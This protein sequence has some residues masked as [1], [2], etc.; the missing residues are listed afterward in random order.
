M[1]P[2]LLE[3]KLE[4]ARSLQQLG[5]LA[6]SR[7]IVLEIL[8]IQADQFDALNLLGVLAAQSGDFDAALGHFEAALRIQPDSGA[9]H[10]NR[11]LV[12]Q[13]ERRYESALESFDIAISLD[14]RNI[15]AH[16]GRGNVATQLGLFES[17]LASYDRVLEI[18]PHFFQAQ[19]SRGPLLQKKNDWRSALAAYDTALTINP[20]SAEAHCGRASV[21]YELE[22]FAAAIEASDRSIALNATFAPIHLYR[23]N[24]LRQLG[25]LEEALAT[26]D[27]AISLDPRFAEAF[28]NRGALLKIMGRNDAALSSYDRAITL[29]PQYADAY[30]NRALIH[31]EFGRHDAAAK[32]LESVAGIEPAL[33]FLPGSFLEARM[34]LC[35]WSNL[36]SQLAHLTE[37][38]ER[39]DPASPPFAVLSLVDSPR[40]QLK[41]AETWVRTMCPPND[42]LGRIG[43][44]LPGRTVRIGYF[45]PDF[46]VHPVG[47]LMAEILECHDHSRFEIIGFYFG[48]DVHDYMRARLARTFTQFFDVR[49][50]SATEIAGLARSLNVD[51][52]VDLCGYTGGSRPMIF[53][54]RAAP[55][56]I[57]YLGYPGTMG[58][59]YMDYLI[60]DS[61]V[62]PADQRAHYSE[63]IIYL[64][65]SFLPSD[66]TRTIS[67]RIFKRSELGLPAVG[68]VYCCFNNSYKIGP[69]VFNTWMRILSRVANSVLWLS[70]TNPTAAANLRQAADRHGI[71]E[72]RII[73]AERMASP[74]EHLARLRVADLFLDTLP[75]NAHATA[76]D[77]LWAGVPVLTCMGHCF[78]GRVAAS[79]LTTLKIDNLVASTLVEYETTAV[80]LGSVP[81]ELKA[82]KQKLVAARLTSPLFDIRRFTRSLEAGYFQAQQ[83]YLSDLLPAHIYVRD[84]V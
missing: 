58:S 35:D 49:D 41:A 5:Q 6:D 21:L 39:G 37:S 20:E 30:F 78:A 25:C 26:Y 18:N 57:S 1:N 36:D 84:D 4:H 71:D 28:N 29:N 34:H 27:R 40:L 12:L 9:A 83:R 50:Q 23:A 3:I 48:P 15:A 67:D 53:A 68:V 33:D 54:S 80:V 65:G 52:A 11:G 82:I 79:L 77:A 45:S 73:F 66:S 76:I 61:T 7:K 24:A 32:D 13:Q 56:Q 74:A 55:L 70:A 62:I 42:S 38:I 64:P 47:T 8:E 75:Y 43:R 72:R 14:A 19:L 81:Q 44:R 69:P 10:C 63:K 31:R 51:I 2:H 60:G 22:N 17:A 59:P 46:R 16:Y